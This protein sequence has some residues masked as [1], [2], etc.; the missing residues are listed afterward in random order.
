MGGRGFQ[1]AVKF[2]TS[3]VSCL[4][5]HQH[6]PGPLTG[7][8]NGVVLWSQAGCEKNKPGPRGSAYRPVK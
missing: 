8:D 5:Q 4:S 2:E 3:R 6:P 7:L 1:Y